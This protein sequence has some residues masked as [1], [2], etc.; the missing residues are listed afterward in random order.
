MAAEAARA[1]GGSDAEYDPFAYPCRDLDGNDHTLLV[2]PLGKRIAIVLDGATA[3]LE[4][5]AVLDLGDELDDAFMTDAPGGLMNLGTTT[6]QLT[7]SVMVIDTTTHTTDTRTVTE[8]ANA[9]L[10]THAYSERATLYLGSIHST[11]TL[12]LDLNAV[13]ALKTMFAD[14]ERVMLGDV[15]PERPDNDTD[16]GD[17]AEAPEPDVRESETAAQLEQG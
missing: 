4:E 15:V 9:S 14:A 17:N 1:A 13:R 3:V 12:S 10:D 5:Q 6:G 7:A 11:T 16:D 2:V 8:Q